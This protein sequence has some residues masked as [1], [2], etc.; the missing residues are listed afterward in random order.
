MQTNRITQHYW[1]RYRVEP[2]HKTAKPRQSTEDIERDWVEAKRRR[3]RLQVVPRT[4]TRD[5]I[6]MYNLEVKIMDWIGRITGVVA[7]MLFI[8]F[9]GAVVT[10]VRAG[11]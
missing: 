3:Q 4:E 11:W 9:I 6:E 10:A 8:W 2:I 5:G 1:N 7:S